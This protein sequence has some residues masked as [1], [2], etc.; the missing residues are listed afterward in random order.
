MV[1]GCPFDTQTLRLLPRKTYTFCLA[2]G[3]LFVVRRRGER[4]P[5][6]GQ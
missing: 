4:A 3:I 2:Q 5:E 1:K 6:R